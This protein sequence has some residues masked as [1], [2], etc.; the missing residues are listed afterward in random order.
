ML[1]KDAV[2]NAMEMIEA[3]P[4]S[5]F[6]GYNLKYGSKSYGSLTDVK[7]NKIIEMPV[8]EQLMTGLATGMAMSGWLPVLIFERHDF[9]LLAT[10]QII[11]HLIKMKSMTRGAY[12]PKVIIRAIVGGTVPFYP[13]QQHDQ[14]FSN[15]FQ[16]CTNLTMIK[17]KT[18]DEVHEAYDLAVTTNGP[19]LISEER[20]LYND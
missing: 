20:D 17:P 12:D 14:D 5:V 19:V 8:A 4:N 9:L 1:Y 11:N 13:G 18:A 15:I 3:M 6:V 7:P 16:D 10:D 2:K